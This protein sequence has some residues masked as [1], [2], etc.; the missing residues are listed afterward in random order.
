MAIL[1]KSLEGSFKMM[2]WAIIGLAE[3]LFPRPA[4][5]LEADARERVSLSLPLV[6][7]GKRTRGHYGPRPS[8]SPRPPS[9][10]VSAPACRCS[11]RPRRRGRERTS[12]QK[13]EDRRAHPFPV[14]QQRGRKRE[15][16]ARKIRGSLDFFSDWPT[17]RHLLLTDNIDVEDVG[18]SL[19]PLVPLTAPRRDGHGRIGKQNK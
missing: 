6:A 14:S 8:P 9:L 12:A 13:G 16:L 2:F 11:Y 7:E 10:R 15:L 4:R 5:N 18:S 17:V 19:E 3:N 1:D